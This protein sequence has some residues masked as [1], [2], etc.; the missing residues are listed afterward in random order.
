VTNG[1]VISGNAN[2]RTQNI[3]EILPLMAFG[4]PRCMTRPG[5]AKSARGYSIRI[6]RYVFGRSIISGDV[7]WGEMKCGFPGSCLRI[8]TFPHRILLRFS[9]DAVLF[10]LTHGD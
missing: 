2:S 8:W 3:W 10:G 9:N 5:R 7:V 4:G 1:L 6:A